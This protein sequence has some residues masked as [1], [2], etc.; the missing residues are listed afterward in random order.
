MVVTV[1]SRDGSLSETALADYITRNIQN[2]VS[3]VPGVG[4]FQLFASGRAMRVWVDP[5]KLT[6]FKLSMGDVNNAIGRQN[7]LISGGIMG[8]PPN[9]EAQRVA[10]PIVVNG[11]LS[12]VQAFGDIVLR[13]N[14]DGSR[15]EG[16]TSALQSLIRISYA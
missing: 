5:D 13:A 9:P 12:T 6:G 16:H 3:R 1:S 15:S 4:K 14:V 10:A 8:S 2:P 11:Q 7:V